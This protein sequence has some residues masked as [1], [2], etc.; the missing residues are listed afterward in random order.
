M[1]PSSQ[2]VKAVTDFLASQGVSAQPI[3]VH[4]D[5]LGFDTTAAQAGRLF[6]ASF[7][8]YHHVD[9]DTQ[10]VRTMAYSVPA[11]LKEHIA[12]VH[13]MTTCVIPA[14]FLPLILNKGLIDLL[15][16]THN[17]HPH[18]TRSVLTVA[19]HPVRPSIPRVAT[20]SHPFACKRSMASQ[21]SQRP[22]RLTM[23]SSST[24]T[25]LSLP[26]RQICRSVS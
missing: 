3:S 2:S 4:G 9:S 14:L 17:V 5:W 18:A 21:R 16:R 6:N 8:T 1:A 13:P 15:L 7:S 11:H 10:H 23:Y 22:H 25:A 12:L 19:G 24:V 20:R 26:R